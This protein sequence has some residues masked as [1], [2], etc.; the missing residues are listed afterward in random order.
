MQI[1]Q[2]GVTHDGQRFLF[3]QPRPNDA[4]VVPPMTVVVNW[5]TGLK[6]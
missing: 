6:K 4:V 1:D 2:Y 3:I 5:M